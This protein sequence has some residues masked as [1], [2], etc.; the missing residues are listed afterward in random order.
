MKAL[1]LKDIYLLKNNW[2]GFMIPIVIGFMPVLFNILTVNFNEYAASI[3]KSIFIFA[4]FY[5]S[6]ASIYY[7]DESKFLD[8]VRVTPAGTAEY[9]KSKYLLSL[10]VYLILF[11]F[12]I[13]MSLA[14]MDIISAIYTSL[15]STAALSIFG[16]ITLTLIFKFGV[17]NVTQLI[18]ILFF[19]IVLIYT[20]VNMKGF[21]TLNIIES[22]KNFNIYVTVSI[23]I[24][25]VLTFFSCQKLSIKILEESKG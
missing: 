25:S 8:Y 3:F 4:I 11:L 17:K 13:L 23:L 18:Y 15:L 7:D 20:F 16:F 6:Y 19:S 2:K 9:V 5:T 21:T 1:L 24:L 14:D 10:F 12:L 22:I